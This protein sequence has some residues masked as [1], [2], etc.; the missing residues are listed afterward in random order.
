MLRPLG[1]RGFSTSAVVEKLK[2]HK[3]TA[4]RFSITGTGIVSSSLPSFGVPAADRQYRHD[5]ARKREQR[6]EGTDDSG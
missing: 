3:G 2:T 5:D 1:A 4:K 6:T